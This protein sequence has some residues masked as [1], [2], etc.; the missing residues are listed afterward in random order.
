MNCVDCN[1]EFEHKAKG[2][3]SSRCVDCRRKHWNMV[4]K[5]YKKGVTNAHE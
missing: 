2:R 3:R 5:S 4:R 1:V